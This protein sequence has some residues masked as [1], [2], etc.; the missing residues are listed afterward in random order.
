MRPTPGSAGGVRLGS[1]QLQGPL[2][3][4]GSAVFPAEG[5]V[6]FV[7]SGSVLAGRDYRCARDLQATWIDS[8]SVTNDDGIAPFCIVAGCF[9]APA[10]VTPPPVTPSTV[11]SAQGVP[12]DARC[13]ILPAK[14]RATTA[15]LKLLQK[16]AH[17]GS[18][19]SPPGGDATGAGARPA[20]HRAARNRQGSLLFYSMRPKSVAA[21]Q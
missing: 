20:P 1:A 2:D 6:T 10:G 7:F 16:A 4:A 13:S 14:I 17:R 8:Q 15:R 5:V 18:A 19:S 3:F 12:P 21:S 11:V 9:G